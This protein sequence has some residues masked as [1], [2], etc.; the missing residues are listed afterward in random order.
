[1]IR[2]NAWIVASSLM[3]AAL[4]FANGPAQVETPGSTDLQQPASFATESSGQV[5]VGTTTLV[6]SPGHTVVQYQASLTDRQFLSRVEAD[7]R[8]LG[9]DIFKTMAVQNM[10]VFEATQAEVSQALSQAEGIPVARI[11][12]SYTRNGDPHPDSMVAF[13]SRIA[14]RFTPE[15]TEA[16]RKQWLDANGFQRL[17]ETP[18]GYVILETFQQPNAAMIAF[19]EALESDGEIIAEAIYEFV[20]TGEPTSASDSIQ[21]NDPFFR[22]QWW[23]ANS[24]NNTNIPELNPDNDIDAPLA[25]MINQQN[26]RDR[27]DIATPRQKFG[28]SIVGLFDSGVEITH[29]D[30]AP[31]FDR[32]AS[33]H[34]QPGSGDPPLRRDIRTLPAG[35]DFVDGGLPLPGLSDLGAHGTFMAGLIGAAVNNAGIVGAAPG[36][37][38][39][40]VRVFSADYSTS[41]LRI[42]TG[43]Q[44]TI[45]RNTDL[46]VHPYNL[47]IDLDCGLSTTLESGFRQAW[48]AGRV[49]RGVANL[50]AAGNFVSQV[51]YPA[52]SPWVIAVGGVPSSGERLSVFPGIFTSLND[53]NWGGTG[54]D[55]VMPSHVP[56]STGGETEY[57][58]PIT[59]TDMTGSVG[60]SNG[61]Y[62]S[63]AN[64]STAVDQSRVYPYCPDTLT[65][66]GMPFRGSSFATALAGG[67][68]SLMMTD[69][70]YEDLRPTA[71][72]RLRRD[73]DDLQLPVSRKE[74]RERITHG[75]DS[76]LRQMALHADLPG[77]DL[78]TTLQTANPTRLARGG[79]LSYIDNY[80]EFMGFGQ[81]N[82]ARALVSPEPW[83][84]RDTFHT[85]LLFD[86]PFYEVDFVTMAPEGTEQDEEMGV[87]VRQGWSEISPLSITVFVGQGQ[88]TVPLM[89][90]PYIRGFNAIYFENGRVA[91]PQ[92]TEED[93]LLPFAW[94]DS[95]PLALENTDSDDS[96]VPINLYWNPHGRYQANQTLGIRSPS[97]D[98]PT[99]RTPML[100]EMGLAHQ[101]GVENASSAPSVLREIDTI[102]LDL[103]HEAP[104]G[105]GPDV[106]IEIARITGDSRRGYKNRLIPG[107]QFFIEDYGASRTV[108][109]GF[110]EPWR[111]AEGIEEGM[112]VR[113]YQ[114]YAPPIPDGVGSFVLELRLNP[115]PSYLP[116]YD[117]EGDQ[118]ISVL[119]DHL[120]FIFTDLKITNLRPSYTDYLDRDV[121][122]VADGFFPSWNVNAGK[123]FVTQR[124][125]GQLGH[126]ITLVDPHP[127]HLILD[128]A[129]PSAVESDAGVFTR[130]NPNLFRER[131]N[132]RFMDTRD[133]VTGMKSHPFLD[134]LAITTTGPSGDQLNIVTADGINFRSLLPSSQTIGARDP[135]FSP[136]GNLL[137]FAGPNY[138]RLVTLDENLEVVNSETILTSAT[139]GF[140]TDFRSPVVDFDGGLIF[141][142]ARRFDPNARHDALQLY[143]VTRSGRVV[144]YRP[145]SREPFLPGWEDEN[146]NGINIF[147]LDL[148]RSGR[149]LIFSANASTAPV[150]GELGS[151]NV[152][153]NATPSLNAR[154]FTIDNFHHVQTNND[155][156]L[157]ERVQFRGT[158]PNFPKV[159]GRY[160]RLSPVSNEIAWMAYPSTIGPDDISSEA[161]IVRQPLDTNEHTG[162]PINIITPDPVPDI[163]PTGT[164]A[165]PDLA[166]IQVRDEGNFAN[167]NEGWTFG[168]APGALDL[169]DGQY[170]REDGR[171]QLIEPGLIALSSGA[172]GPIGGQNVLVA[173]LSFRAQ[174]PGASGVIFETAEPHR[175]ILMD[176]DFRIIASELDSG[177]VNVID[178]VKTTTS[179]L[180]RLFLNFP[181]GTNPVRGDSFD[182]QVRLDGNL[183]HAQHF[184]IFLRYDPSVM[185]FRFGNVNTSVFS[186][187]LRGSLQLLANSSSDRIYGFY[188][189]RPGDLVVDQDALYLFRANVRGVS[190]TGNLRQMPMMRLRVNSRNFESAFEAITQPTGSDLSLIPTTDRVRSYDLLFRPPVENYLIPSNNT[191]VR[192]GGLF[193]APSVNQAYTAAF[194]LINTMPG[195]DPQSGFRLE[196][197]TIYRLDDL[198]VVDSAQQVNRQRSVIKDI[199][200]S[201][202]VPVGN[203]AVAAGIWNSGPSANEDLPFQVANFV[204]TASSLGFR[205]PSGDDTHG[206]W[207]TN[208][209]DLPPSANLEPPFWINEVARVPNLGG[210]ERDAA[211]VEIAGPAGRSLSG[212][213]LL[214]YTDGGL[215]RPI[216][217][218]ALT[219]TLPNQQNG[220]GTLRHDIIYQPFNEDTPPGAAIALALQDPSGEVVQ[221]VSYNQTVQAVDGPAADL[222]STFTA[223]IT[224]ELQE[225]GATVQLSGTGTRLSDFR[226]NHLAL[227]GSPGATNN[228]QAFRAYDL[229]WINEIHHLDPEPGLPFPASK[230]VE[231]AGVAGTNLAGWRFVY[232]NPEGTRVGGRTIT[233]VIPNQSG[234][235]GTLA[236]TTPSLPAAAGSAVA[237]VNNNGFVVDF[238]GYGGATRAVGDVAD[239]LVAMEIAP[240]PVGGMPLGSLQLQGIGV[241]R[242]DFTWSSGQIGESFGLINP[243]QRIGTEIYRATFTITNPN[244][245]DLRKIPTLRM[246][247]GTTDFQRISM[248][249]ALA[250]GSNGLSTVPTPNSPRS[251]EVYMVLES[252]PR[253]LTRLFAAYD[254]VHFRP[255][256]EVTSEVLRME[257]LVIERLVVPDYPKP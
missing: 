49:G 101:L 66:A 165:P 102:T 243:G 129:G 251:Y 54:I 132:Q 160:A 208:R 103:I 68:L 52:M 187:V 97:I 80:N 107:T 192:R 128:P 174:F 122:E 18:L 14:V 36:A 162:G 23:L 55:I 140:L 8:S 236:F 206:F 110:Y 59:S 87:V 246:R 60:L 148:S 248:A 89:I 19:T 74:F 111:P 222:V 176:E 32:E 212:W 58:T 79:A 159:S 198:R 247:L 48:E 51:A 114:F 241:R 137:L 112:L 92:V 77:A 75:E 91:L 232:Y 46:N 31:A 43:L 95:L 17:V 191:A 81:P 155:P 113:D 105:E 146:G 63:I 118:L 33:F 188:E 61:D 244:E 153:L 184:R 230:R 62:V 215:V 179:D 169:A 245:T 121:F 156:P 83:K 96:D 158:D 40:A 133:R 199:V 124:L 85:D 217:N 41:N 170:F 194:D 78:S 42:L 223:A 185:E 5:K 178:P 229:T 193:D 94:T 154:L 250:N 152:L 175:T 72:P 56:T 200:G 190:G 207:D 151:S 231:V 104:G 26:I 16:A 171:P 257:N 7:A 93:R 127:A 98:A 53:S 147:D 120:G 234:R 45:A 90:S 11:L 115:G 182:V 254:I 10:V 210:F 196:S 131:R 88:E 204:P 24:G 9:L 205:L 22:L 172:T 21:V 13:T 201:Y 69:P 20:L 167:N 211:W 6:P 86:E 186:K 149:R 256:Q 108:W 228:Q 125:V 209:I 30:L 163:T 3:V 100:I 214:V 2:K 150:P 119:R 134:Y 142:T 109:P 219:G 253:N 166:T 252:I 161:R 255:D 233:G 50:G 44:D 238:I 34:P 123:L 25:W 64:Y 183:G 180:P 226:W 181:G 195:I 1:M 135:F 145:D 130:A 76:L 28:N 15:S 84:T 143:G 144:S 218:G 216:E 203:A 126:A 57:A 12:P 220:Y 117:R 99:N 157:Y 65:M 70:R 197:Y 141:F 35:R 237:L 82:P 249:S 27:G 29:N 189:T 173:T 164:P 73:S 213:N 138:I 38:I 202:E 224:D 240:E 177:N 221:F 116:S 4:A 235:Y 37:Q 67:V 239:G 106:R 227:P 47:P 225:A 242:S 136:D 39:Y 168:G 71:D 139:S